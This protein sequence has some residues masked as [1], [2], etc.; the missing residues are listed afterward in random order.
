MENTNPLK[1]FYR[2]PQIYIALPTGGKYY[3]AEVVQKTTN[4]EHAVLPMTAVDEMAFKMPDSLMNGQSTVDVIRSCIPT[5]QDPWSIV[6]YDLDT[7]LIAIRIAS[8]GENMDV[9]AGV[10][11]TD[12]Q[13]T[14]S[15][16]LPKMLDQ[17]RTQ[18]FSDECSL[19]SGLKIKVK[20]LTYKQ[21]TEAQLKTFEQQRIY[22]Q[23]NDSEMTPEE[24]TKRF[25][26]SFKQL[27]ALNSQMLL[28]N[29]AEIVSPSGDAVKDPALIKDFIDNAD[30]KTTKELETKLSV[31]RQQGA[32][33]PFR[34]NATEEQI[35]NGAPSTYEV[36]VTFDNA[37]FFV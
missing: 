16:N 1:Q 27:N 7:I 31:I 33:K 32:I 22:A 23:V 13:V 30:A 4:N 11:G 14:H 34:V 12:E 19:S 28:D 36:P 2:Q 6:N 20:P 5:I 3:G 10:P 24:K 37:N 29:I 35:K 25:S 15:I 17:L 18:T 21:I 8:Y 9:T 26:D